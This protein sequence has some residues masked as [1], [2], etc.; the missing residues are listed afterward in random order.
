MTRL[1]AAVV[2]AI[3]E[4]LFLSRLSF[5]IA[6]FKFQIVGR[7]GRPAAPFSCL[8]RCARSSV[9]LQ[10]L[11]FF[12]YLDFSVPWILIQRV[13][14]SGENQQCTRNAERMQGMV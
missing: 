12:A 5:Q 11:Q 9:F 6:D 1:E 2:V 3:P 4:Q 13:P 7:R 14:F 10:P 8:L